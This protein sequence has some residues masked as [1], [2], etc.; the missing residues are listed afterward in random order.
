[1]WKRVH[2]ELERINGDDKRLE[3]GAI[4]LIRIHFVLI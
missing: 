1:M 2:R 3:K 4:V